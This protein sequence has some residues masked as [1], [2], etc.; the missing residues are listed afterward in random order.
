MRPPERI[1]VFDNDGTLWVEQEPLYT[2]LVF[3]LDRIHELAPQNS[4]GRQ[5]PLFHAAIDRD[6]RSIAAGVE[7]S[8]VETHRRG[9]G[10]QY[11]RSFRA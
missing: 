5:D 2:Q 4:V 3:I 8:A 9:A 10:R 11:A 7:R 1:A 6:L